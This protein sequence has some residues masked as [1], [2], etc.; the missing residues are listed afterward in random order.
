M[1]T[2]TE[3]SK[4]NN[5]PTLLD[6]IEKIV[7]LS[8]KRSKEIEK[9]E[10][11]KEELKKHLILIMKT[12]KMSRYEALVFS[13]IL[14]KSGSN[15][16]TPELLAKSLNC[17]HIRLLKYMDYVD[18]LEEKGL[19]LKFNGRY[20][21][22]S[23][24]Y[25]VP[26]NVIN[27]L[28]KGTLPTLERFYNL[29]AEGYFIK[30]GEI[31]TSRREYEISHEH[32]INTINLLIED[33][34]HLNFCRLVKDYD[35]CSNDLIFFLRLCKFLVING[36]DGF[37]LEAFDNLKAFFKN[38]LIFS[39]ISVELKKGKGPL[40]EKE[41]IEHV[42]DKGFRNTK[43][44]QITTKARKELLADYELKNQIRTRFHHDIIKCEQLKEKQLFYNKEEANMVSR[45]T[46]LLGNEN[47]NSIVNRL[48][49][50]NMRTGFACLFS[51][52]PGT[53]KTETAYQ[54]AKITNRGI[55][56]VEI[57]ESKSAWFGESE[58]IIKDIFVHYRKE[59]KRAEKSGENIPMIQLCLFAVKK[60]I[61]KAVPG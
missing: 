46:S 15:A 40:F 6:H 8:G 58:K 7:R 26:L 49:E 51:G 39:K 50:S 61:I 38:D 3:R 54:L 12:L 19:I 20:Q 41:L 21:D 55:I 34:L 24:Y 48:S 32:F 59:V 52:P 31:F 43:M 17:S 35:L 57:S 13:H 47:Y 16:V 60:Q 44:V 25:Y 18:K 36:E 22:R 1:K 56:P 28:R 33:N 9:R 5:S 42:N 53:G 10:Q 45:L 37:D 4:V 29:D 11:N 27:S 14:N 23:P 30:Q 2:L